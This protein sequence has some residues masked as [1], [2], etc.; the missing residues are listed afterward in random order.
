MAAPSAFGQT[1]PAMRTIPR[2]AIDDLFGALMRRGY[3]LV[4]PRLRDQAI[5][6]SEIASAG[7][8]PAGWT[9]EQEGGRYRL[10]RTDD[11]TLFGYTVGPHS[12]KKYLHPPALRL[13]RAERGGDS[14][15]VLEE[16]PPEK[17]YAF[18]GVRSCELHAMSIQDRVFLGGRHVD[19]TY[20]RRRRQAFIVAVQCGL[21]GGTCF[22][23]SMGTGPRASSGFD[24]ALTEVLADGEHYF[25]VES[26]SQQGEA[27]LEELAARPATADET[28][29]AARATARAAADMGRHLETEGLP[30][31]LRRNPE[32]PRW[33]EVAERCLACGNCTLVCPTCFCTTVED[34]AEL[35][36]RFAERRRRWDSCFNADFS[37]IHGG[38]VRPSTRAR[39]RQWMTHKLST[40][41]DQFG[42]SGCVGC[43]RCITWCPVGID[44]TEEA[45]AIQA[46]EPSETSEDDR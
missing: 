33:G 8:L 10:V 15:R 43:G 19:P 29:A 41:H 20:R 39:Y 12:W 1:F 18:I 11:E 38:A 4:G 13:W 36:G 23:A 17:P 31:L 21:A 9:D 40:W 45:R 26:A 34:T 16:E 3:T 32:H 28:R 27:V 25:V 14:F 42:T 5:V 22:C 2:S 46:G 7:D 6:Y 44:L 30:E 37:Y 24:L 35:Q